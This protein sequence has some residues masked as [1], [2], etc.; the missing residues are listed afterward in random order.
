MSQK[1]M[2]QYNN[3]HSI[4]DKFDSLYYETSECRPHRLFN[5][6]YPW[7][8][9][10]LIKLFKD[11]NTDFNYIIADTTKDT[12]KIKLPKYNPKN[13]IVC[14]SGGK[15]SIATVLHYKKLGYNIYLYHLRNINKAYPKEYKNA[16]KIADELGLMLYTEE[17]TLS[18]NH[19]YT[20][21]PMKNIMIANAALHF[22]IRNNIGIKI[23]FGNYYTAQLKDNEFD[24]CAG[25]CRDMWT[26]YERII[27]RII[28]LFKMYIPLKNIKTTL[29][30]LETHKNLLSLSCSCISPYRYREYWKKQNQDKYIIKLPENRCG[31]C[32]KCALE[33]IYYT[34]HNIWQYNEEFYRHCLD[35]L[36]RNSIKEHNKIY[37]IYQLWNSY[38]FY[39]ISKSKYKGVQDAIIQTRKIK[40]T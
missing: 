3:I 2:H 18:G 39:P 22:G 17:I 5:V 4:F 12:K 35:I 40:F 33:Y 11:Y 28:P 30:A 36:L 21:H 7:Y 20:E 14:F 34:D 13:I 6:Y 9:N 38:L 26:I 29:K 23:A 24:V 1:V 19:I 10:N 32:W 25:D 16:E 15:D 37:S 8:F 31:T 27:Q